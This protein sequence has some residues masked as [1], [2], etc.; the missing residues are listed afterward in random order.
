MLA[1]ARSAE[2]VPPICTLDTGSASV[3]GVKLPPLTE[4]GEDVLALAQA[5]VDHHAR[6]QK[7]AVRGLD[8]AAGRGWVLVDMKQDW[9]T[10]YPP[11]N[12]R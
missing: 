12:K 10:I 6:A 3:D 1:P 4:R 2:R 11:A 5:F 9:K 8:E 7:K